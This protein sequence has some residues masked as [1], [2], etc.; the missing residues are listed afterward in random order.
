MTFKRG[1]MWTASG[2]RFDLA[3]PSP[4][5]VEIE[6]IAHS[7][8]RQ[9]RFTGHV[10]EHY[11]VAQHSVLVSE[12]CDPQ[13]AL[14]GLLH[15]ASEAYV[16]DLPYPVKSLPGIAAPFRAL[17]ARVQRAVC[18][19]FSLEMKM[20]ASVHKVDKH[21][22]YVEMY[23]LMPALPGETRDTLWAFGYAASLL[24]F[25]TIRP[26]SAEKAREMFMRRFRVVRLAQFGVSPSRQTRKRANLS[27][28]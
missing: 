18:K 19:R 2:V 13:D 6:D 26:V 17:E 4:D 27:H 21:L 15:D 25:P 8:S 12:M 28:V 10:S 14:W 20:P 1:T 3:R 16:S 22:A 24:G 9:C 7:L 23:D 5:Q 11:S